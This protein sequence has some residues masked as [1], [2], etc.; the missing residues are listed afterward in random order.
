[1]RRLLIVFGIPFCFFCLGASGE[2]P[3]PPVPNGTFE[4]IDKATGLPEGWHA[5]FGEGTKADIQVDYGES[6]TGNCSVRI[7]D[8]S[9][10]QAYIYA[11]FQSPFLEVSPQTTYLIRFFLKGKNVG[12][13]YV[14][15]VFEGAGEHRQTLPVE[16]YD[17]Q[18]AFFQITTPAEC[19]RMAIQFVADGITDALWVDDVTLELAPHQL[20]NLAE[21]RYQK[22][23]E[24]WFPRTPGQVPEHL[25]VC[26]V[27]HQNSADNM[28]AVALQGIVNRKGPQ[29]YLINQTNPLYYDEV[30]LEYM[31]EKGYTGLEERVS[32]PLE[33]IRCFKESING[34][35]V[36]DPDLPGSIN[37]K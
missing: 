5:G 8:Q 37:A 15:A 24:S 3:I 11:L 13:F 28:L 7:S 31:K 20:A 36:Y 34:I 10:T 33:L 23:Y 27:S 30:W 26:D 16:D 6:H 4:I 14:G 19:R 1:M 12:K 21:I 2:Q 35:I 29:I 18:E 25:V 9:P 22:D 32:D 17:W